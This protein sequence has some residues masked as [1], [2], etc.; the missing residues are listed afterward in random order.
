M[1][2]LNQITLDV[3]L[4]I[5]NWNQQINSFQGI[6]GKKRAKKYK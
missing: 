2:F 5:Y 4:K 1:L 6:G 3:K